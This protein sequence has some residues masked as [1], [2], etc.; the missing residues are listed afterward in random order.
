MSRD[1]GWEMGIKEAFSDSNRAS[2]KQRKN[3]K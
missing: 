2:Q 3:Y 1:E